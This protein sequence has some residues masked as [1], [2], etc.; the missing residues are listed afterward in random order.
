MPSL[1]DHPPP[2]APGSVES[3]C[4]YSVLD[5]AKVGGVGKDVTEDDHRPA[6]QCND[7]GLG[8][9]AGASLLRFYPR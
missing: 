8:L 1:E 9:S 5:V 2:T 6:V 4:I 7:E 3:H